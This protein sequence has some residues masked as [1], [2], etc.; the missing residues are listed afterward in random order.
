VRIL[1]QNAILYQYC[2]IEIEIAAKL[3]KQ[4]ILPLT[5]HGDAPRM[6]HFHIAIHG[7][8]FELIGNSLDSKHNA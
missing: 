6:V 1:G 7:S 8:L 5:Q 3:L 2:N 4:D